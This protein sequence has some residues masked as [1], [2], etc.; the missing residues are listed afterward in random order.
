[1]SKRWRRGGGGVERRKVTRLNQ[2]VPLLSAKR[3]IARYSQSRHL[4]RCVGCVDVNMRDDSQRVAASIVKRIVRKSQT[5]LSPNA[6]TLPPPPPTESYS[7]LVGP[8]L[9]VRRTSLPHRFKEERRATYFA[10]V[11]CRPSK[12]LYVTT[13]CTGNPR[14]PPSLSAPPPP[15]PALS[16]PFKLPPNRFLGGT[17]RTEVIS[18]GPAFQGAPSLK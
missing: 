18:R 1:M 9:P 13:R 12:S 11:L 10:P 7:L 8:S 16:L 2:S 6:H 14:S 15:S 5:D 4:H 17:K 3:R